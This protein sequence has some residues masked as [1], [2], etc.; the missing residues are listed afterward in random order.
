MRKEKETF[1][2]K[3]IQ[4]DGK[5]HGI[6]KDRYTYSSTKILDKSRA[7]WE[8]G[9]KRPKVDEGRKNKILD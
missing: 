8:S 6:L 7:K 3:Y 1:R 4:T 9:S 2:S 5:C